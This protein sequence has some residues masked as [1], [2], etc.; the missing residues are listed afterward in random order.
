MVRDPLQ[1]R[2]GLGPVGARQ[3]LRVHAGSQVCQHRPGQY[4][5]V[6][7]GA[8]AAFRV[9]HQFHL[10]PAR[11]AQG[12]GYAPQRLGIG[13]G[14]DRLG[15]PLAGHLQFVGRD[16][17]GARLA[18][19]MDAVARRRLCP[20]TPGRQPQQQRQ[21]QA[22]AEM[23]AVSANETMGPARN[24]PLNALRANDHSRT[25]TESRAA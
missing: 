14:Q 3:G 8:D 16:H 22:G 7:F 20:A 4:A 9:E 11:P 25:L 24:Q 6:I 21:Q 23:A 1:R 5:A 2:A 10:A 19:V 13:R 12:L 17:E 15:P 18:V